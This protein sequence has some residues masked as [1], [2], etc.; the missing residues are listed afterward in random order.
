MSEACV[1]H[2]TQLNI[3]GLLQQLFFHDYETVKNNMTDDQPNTHKHISWMGMT[4]ICAWQH[5][6]ELSMVDLLSDCTFY[7]NDH[8][9]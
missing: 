9:C 8:H 4:W 3:I 7:F 1:F 5:L 6:S 2:V